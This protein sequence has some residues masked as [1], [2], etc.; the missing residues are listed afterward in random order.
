MKRKV[1]RPRGSGPVQL[2]RTV[3]A[4]EFYLAVKELEQR[5]A[6]L[7]KVRAGQPEAD[8]LLTLTKP[9]YATKHQSRFH[10]PKKLLQSFRLCSQ[11]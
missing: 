10:Q 1:G 3:I 8:P 9:M 5:G 7:S 4:N 2:I 6:S 11:D